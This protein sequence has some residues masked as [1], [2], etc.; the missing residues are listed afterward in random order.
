MSQSPITSGIQRLWGNSTPAVRIIALTNIIVFA[1]PALADFVGFRI[2]GIS[3][4]N[5]LLIWGAKDNIAIAAGDQYYRFIT[6]MFL[7]G[8]LLHLLFLLKQGYYS[9]AYA[10]RDLRNK[11]AKS[12]AAFTE[13]NYWETE[14]EYTVLV[15]YRSFGGRHDELVGY[16]VAN[17]FNQR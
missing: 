7:H 2:L 4:G 13:G 17:S 14:N 3:V 11:E 8:G 5:L 15:Y 9:Y 10:T 1:I 12:N 6:M 16:S